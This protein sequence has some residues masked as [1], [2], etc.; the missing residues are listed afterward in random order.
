[1]CHAHVGGNFSAGFQKTFDRGRAE[2]FTAVSNIFIRISRMRQVK[3]RLRSFWLLMIQLYPIYRGYPE[4]FDQNYSYFLTA[5]KT[6]KRHFL[7]H[8]LILKY[9]NRSAL[10][11]SSKLCSP[12]AICLTERATDFGSSFFFFLVPRRWLKRR[13]GAVSGPFLFQSIDCRAIPFFTNHKNFNKAVKEHSDE[14]PS[15]S[16]WHVYS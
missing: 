1:M 3:S 11:A 13:S 4:I 16:G 9:L 14:P 5:G 6:L 10:F 2:F 7:L 8:I 12:N 15:S